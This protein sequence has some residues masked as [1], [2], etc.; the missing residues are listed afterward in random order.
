MKSVLL[1]IPAIIASASACLGQTLPDGTRPIRVWLNKENEEKPVGIYLKQVRAAIGRKWI[2]VVK[3]HP[4]FY[5]PGVVKVAFLIDRTGKVSHVQITSSSS[6]SEFSDDCMKIIQEAEIPA[7]P[8]VMLD[9]MRNQK[10]LHEMAFSILP[11]L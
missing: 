11:P 3:K 5:Q 8:Q 10:L 2:V 4:E 9:E 7:P 6:N 1:R